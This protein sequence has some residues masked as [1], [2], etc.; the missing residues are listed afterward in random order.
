MTEL[1]FNKQNS[2]MRG[3]TREELDEQVALVNQFQSEALQGPVKSKFAL[4]YK[5]DT[6]QAIEQSLE[7]KK[8]EIAKRKT[9]GLFANVSMATT[10]GNWMK[11]RNW[12]HQANQVYKSLEDDREQREL[13]KLDNKKQ[14][15]RIQY[16]ALEDQYKL[17]VKH[18]K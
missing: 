12:Q 17:H 1:S 9:K 14:Q 10:A 6:D 8:M 5:F 13:E 18:K 4:R 3:L 15:K 11:D 7:Y 16:M 2:Q